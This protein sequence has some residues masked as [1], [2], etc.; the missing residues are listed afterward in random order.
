M[1]T[2]KFGLSFLIAAAVLTSGAS[3][4][5][6]QQGRQADPNPPLLFGESNLAADPAA[7]RRALDVL[8]EQLRSVSTPDRVAVTMEAIER[9]WLESGSPTANLLMERA[10]LAVRAQNLE[11]AIEI[12]RS[13]TAVA[14]AYAQGWVQ[15][16]LA[17]M[18]A[19]RSDEAQPAL[20]RALALEPD[21]FK[22]VEAY[23]VLLR[24]K[25]EKRAAL[26]AFRRALALNPHSEYAR[27]AEE[28]LTREVEGRGI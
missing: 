9:L 20:L 4:L 27:M 18:A 2:N 21:H 3:T 7:R 8:Y 14:P 13:L 19:G 1:A 11:L 6:A 12:L 23:A 15:L 10:F 22:A 17:Y 24:G 25:G 16:A 5:N 26:A 28:A